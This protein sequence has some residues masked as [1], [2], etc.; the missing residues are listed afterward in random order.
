MYLK[1]TI[2][3][4]RCNGLFL[5][6]YFFFIINSLFYFNYFF[7]FYTNYHFFDS[8]IFYEILRLQG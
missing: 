3:D 8:D 6:T 7:I 5:R 1:K 4:D 2:S